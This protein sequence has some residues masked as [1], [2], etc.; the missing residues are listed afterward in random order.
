MDSTLNTYRFRIQSVDV[1][2]GIVMIIMALDHVRLYMGATSFAPVDPTQTSVALFFTRWITHFCAPVFIFLAGTSAFLY[3]RNTKCDLATLRNF[4]LTRGLWIIMVEIL[5]LNLAV[6]FVPYQFLLLQVL[7]VIGWSMIIL[8]G[9]IYL[10]KSAILLI[11][12]LLIFGHNLLDYFFAEETGWFY[13][14]LHLQRLIPAKPL[15]IFIHYPLLPWPGVMALGYLFGRLLVK[16][17]PNRNAQIWLIGLISITL[18]LILRGLNIYGDPSPWEGQP[19]GW[20]YTA[21][22]FLNTTKYPPSLLFLLMTLGPAMLIMPWLEK[23]QG[24]KVEFISTFG[25]VPFFF[26]LIHFLVIH[27]IAAIWSQWQFET[28]EWWLGPPSDFPEGYEFNL[29]LVYG[30]WLVVIMLCYPLCKW[31][32]NYKKEHK[33]QRWLSYL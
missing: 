9:L 27:I 33:E 4:L 22:S 19:R 8:A 23:W 16:P 15:A 25:K 24:Q 18:F 13:S 5:L 31:Y 20:I 17:T 3:A 21:L 2:R 14:L 26:Y 7:W 30:V 32:A 29:W 11:G 1:L 12:L 28:T 10:P 6:Q